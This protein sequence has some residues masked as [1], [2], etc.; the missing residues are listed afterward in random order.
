MLA[1]SLGPIKSI[2]N[3]KVADLLEIKKRLGLP[4]CRLAEPDGAPS[5]PFFATPDFCTADG[6]NLSGA[7]NSRVSQGEIDA[8]IVKMTDQVM[9]LLSKAE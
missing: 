2:S 3:E 5:E 1:S 8:L 9:A 6:A 7:G 4:D